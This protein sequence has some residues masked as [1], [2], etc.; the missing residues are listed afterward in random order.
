MAMFTDFYQGVLPLNCLNFGTIILLPKK[1]DAKVIQQYRP[2]CLLNV[3][4][5]IFTKAATNR[6]STIAQKIIRPTQTPFLP[7][8]N[9]M[10]DAVILHETLH[11]LHSKKDEV[12][13][14]I[15][16][17]KAYDKVKLS[18]FT[19]NAKDESVLTKMV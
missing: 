2:I 5:K 13:F 15:D 18:F 14:K 6:L 12:I 16:F 1:K 4:F 7:E 11:E 17:E 10:E 19:T 3:S 9:I 8:R